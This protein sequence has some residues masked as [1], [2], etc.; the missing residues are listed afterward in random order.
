[1]GEN[2]RPADGSLSQT[3]HHIS[4]RSGE[5]PSG[6]TGEMGEGQSEAERVTRSLRLSML[7]LNCIAP[8]K[9]FV[10]NTHLYS[11]GDTS[12]LLFL[13][14]DNSPEYRL[15]G[16]SLRTA[17]PS[18]FFCPISTSNRLPRVIPVYIRLRCSSM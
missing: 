2:E 5:N 12:G 18:A 16:R 4:S 1:M 15:C 17:M 9:I 10:L 11:Q 3:S 7:A 8:G 14:L 13:K 6:S